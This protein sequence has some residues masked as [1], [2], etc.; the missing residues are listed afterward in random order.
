MPAISIIIPVYGTEKFIARCLDSVIAQSFNDYEVIVVNDCTKDNA[1]N[2]VQDYC[3]NHKCIKIIDHV[4][5]QGLMVA[6]RSGYNAASGKYIVFLDS[7][8]TLPVSALSILYSAIESSG[9]RIVTGG[10]KYILDKGTSID[11]VPVIKGVFRSKEAIELCLQHKLNHNLAFGIFDRALFEKKYHTIPNQTNGEDLILF[12]QLVAE[13]GPIQVIPDLVYNYYQ[14]F[15]S[16]SN[17]P[18]TLSKLHQWAN[19]QNFK[20]VFCKS[21]NVDNNYLFR[22]ILEIIGTWSVVKGGKSVYKELDNGIQEKI[23]PISFLKYLPFLRG[24]YLIFLNYMPSLATK[25]T[26]YKRK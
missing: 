4:T 21:L 18:P 20:Y 9:H 6:R 24:L 1:M 23:T 8:D 3:M 15:D 13:A 17:T 12:Y 26:N 25:M 2:I 22:N 19:V 7:D 11:H 14:N 16:S 10:Y 5:N